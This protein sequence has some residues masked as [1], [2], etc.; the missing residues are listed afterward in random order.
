MALTTYISCKAG[1][2]PQK[3]CLFIKKSQVVTQVLK[4]LNS[5]HNKTPEAS[6]AEDSKCHNGDDDFQ[7]DE[8]RVHRHIYHIRSDQTAYLTLSINRYLWTFM[9]SNL[10]IEWYENDLKPPGLLNVR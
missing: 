5:W 1:T 8:S 3:W 7:V 2:H 6:L 10:N 9:S 4:Y